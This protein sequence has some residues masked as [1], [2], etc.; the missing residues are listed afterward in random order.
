M[1]T[2]FKDVDPSLLEEIANQL[3]KLINVPLLNEA[4]ERRLIIFVLSILLDKLL[5]IEKKSPA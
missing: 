3:N 5:E 2:M 4:Q 1:G